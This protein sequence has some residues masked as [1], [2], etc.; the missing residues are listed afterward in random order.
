MRLR[1]LYL[2]VRY[3][4]LY[5]ASAIAAGWHRSVTLLLGSLTIKWQCRVQEMNWKTTSS[6]LTFVPLFVHL[7]LKSGAGWEQQS[8]SLFNMPRRC[9][10]LVELLWTAGAIPSTWNSFYFFR[11]DDMTCDNR[12]NLLRGNVVLK[13]HL[14]LWIFCISTR[15][16]NYIKLLKCF[17]SNENVPNQDTAM[18]TRSLFCWRVF[19]LTHCE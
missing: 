12:Q 2:H 4:L 3:Y 1:F 16:C 6:S 15:H 10:F 9:A 8:A 7:S 5:F 13:S 19:C 18:L 11:N 14:S 17:I